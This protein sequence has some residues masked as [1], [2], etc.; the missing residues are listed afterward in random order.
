MGPPAAETFA[1]VCGMSD[2]NIDPSGNTAAFRA[3]A[4]TPEP[5]VNEPSSRAPLLV[6]VG[7]AALL[8]LALALW[9]AF[10]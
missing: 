2:E 4:S 10:G 9:L 3:F 6:G 8:V 5:A 7:F 1:S